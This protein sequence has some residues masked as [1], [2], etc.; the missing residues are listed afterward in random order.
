MSAVCVRVV[1]V[2][3]L[4]SQVSSLRVLHT[5]SLNCTTEAMPC[6]VHINNCY[7]EG[8][9][10]PWQF[11]PNGPVGLEAHVDVRR[12][13]NGNLVPVIVAQWKARD[14]GSISFLSGTE[15]QVFKETSGQHLC[16]HYIFLQKFQTMRDAN[17]E[18]WSFS[19]DKLAVI[20]G[21]TY[22]VSV[23]SLPKPNLDHT[24][25]NINQT[26]VVPGCKNSAMQRTQ[27]CIDS[28]S[29]WQPNITMN[30]TH[31]DGRTLL[32]TFSTGELSEKYNVFVTCKD[33][34]KIRKLTKNNRTSLNVTFDLESWPLTCCIFTVQIQPYF[35]NCENDCRRM[36][37]SFNICREPRV[38]PPKTQIWWTFSIPLF[39]LLCC[40]AV[41]AICWQKKKKTYPEK[42]PTQPPHREDLPAAQRSVLIIYSRDHPQYTDIVL[43]LCAFLRAKCGT[44]VYLDLLDTASVGVMGRLQWT[45]LQKRRIE[46]SSNKVLVLCS[47][48]VQAKWGAMCGQPRVLL[49]EDVLSPIGDMLTLALQLITPDMQRPASYGKYLVAY[50]EDI[51]GE[52]DV[53]SMF[54]LA[55]KYKLMKHFEEL[56]F[57]ILDLEKYQQGKVHTI[58]GIGIDEYF[59]CPSGKALRN[60]I[61]TF[62]AYQLENPD[63]FEKQCLDSEEEGLGTEC[64]PF[65]NQCT[66][67]ILQCKPVVNHGPPICEYEVEICEDKTGCV[68][69]E[70]PHLNLEFEEPSVLSVQPALNRVYSQYGAVEPP[71]GMHRDGVAHIDSEG[72]SC[73]LA[74]PALQEPVPSRSNEVVFKGETTADGCSA[75]NNKQALQQLLDLQLSLA[76]VEVP[77]PPPS[78]DY[79]T[80]ESWDTYPSQPVEMDENER[81]EASGERPSRW[82]DQGYSSRDSIVREE[83]SP[84][85]IASLAK[86]QEVLY[87]NSPIS[88]GF[89]TKTTDS[90]T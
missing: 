45:E 4:S 37:N 49:R 75:E 39:L 1:L 68:W 76:S 78:L 29:L 27:Y 51:S 57:R 90:L 77:A 56:Y 74:E 11:T 34:K 14:D 24:S 54:D 26:V 42:T 44:E 22:V 9:L 58:E 81:E 86:L 8:W 73:F 16:V 7:Y 3:V 33:V 60:A 79:S 63:W 38:P 32:V 23:A 12:D 52:R 70:I 53:P 87:L 83:P 65:L 88:S 80:Q 46:Q 5:S 19:L 85:S 71:L 55:V 2:F 35:A 61:E 82:S 25:Y 89:Y 67:P 31:P 64:S 84:A 43:K 10:T 13:E 21:E 40:L 69:T 17:G 59:N 18:Q 15:L 62:Q 36:S 72:H 47:R 41:C 66:P 48:G 6:E 30:S 50:F 28:G 20:P